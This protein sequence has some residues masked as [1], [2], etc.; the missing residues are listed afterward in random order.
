MKNMR[1]GEWVE[2]LQKRNVNIVHDIKDI[3]ANAR[4]N[5]GC[6]YQKSDKIILA[7]KASKEVV[8]H[9]LGHW[10]GHET[11]LN[12]VSLNN[13]SVL[14]GSRKIEEAIAWEVTK[15]MTSQFSGS[16]KH[17][18]NW[19][20]MF[21]KTLFTKNEGKCAYRFICKEFNLDA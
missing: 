11:R 21:E 7:P 10:T 14:D 19:S 6:Y 15:L 4:G 1:A 18:Y 13:F 8:F 9:E 3:L 2:F 16:T 17:Y 5:G 20:T 12:R